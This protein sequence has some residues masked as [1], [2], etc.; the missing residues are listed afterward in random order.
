MRFRLLITLAA[1]FACLT[2]TAQADTIFVRGQA[3]PVLG[4]IKSENAKGISVF[5]KKTTE[6]IPAGDVIDVHYDDLKPATLRIADGAYK[7]AKDS[8]KE[9]NES[10]DP[11]KRRAA[12]ATAIAKYGECLKKMDPHKYA[13]RTIRY[14]I[15]MLML[16]QAQTEKQS[17]DAALKELQQFKTNYP[18]SWQINHVMPLIAQI[19]IDAQDF[20]GASTTYG[21]MATMDSLPAEVRSNAK[22]M[23]VQVAVRGGDIKEAQKKLAALE[24]EAAGN[25]KFASRVKMAKAEVLVGL[26]QN[27]EAV[28][29]LN[30]VIKES[31]D[32]DTKALAHNTLG[33][34]LFKANRYNE[35]R[36][37]FIWVDTVFNQDRVQHAKALYYLAKTFALLNDEA[38]A[39]ECRATL[40]EAQFSGTE[41]QARALKETGK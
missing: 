24:S 41:W 28:K 25:P 2:F 29:L 16:R 31:S 19:Q 12:L 34:S 14:K 23:I 33:E 5:V 7:V 37:E 13:N 26:K 18:D 22:L 3:K 39:Q 8:E 9:S 35:A 6:T 20:K 27:D 15:G 38:R 11:A 30:E 21:E 4:D 32:K 36:W 40:M 1:F 17:T 10:A